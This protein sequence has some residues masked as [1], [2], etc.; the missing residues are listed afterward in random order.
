MSADYVLD[1]NVEF[2]NPNNTDARG[3]CCND[4]EGT[5][6]CS[7]ACDVLYL[8]CIRSSGSTL[9]ED[10]ERGQC[11]ILEVETLTGG[12]YHI[13]GPWPVSDDMALSDSI[14]TNCIS[15]IL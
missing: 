12:T 13:S 14:E 3:V 4:A 2:D 9:P 8:V 5:T 10:A 11:P 15:I 1:L 6:N 7:T